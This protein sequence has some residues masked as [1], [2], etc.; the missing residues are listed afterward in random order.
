MIN[1]IIEIWYW[2]ILLI[3]LIGVVFYFSVQFVRDLWASV[4]RQLNEEETL[5]SRE[6]LMAPYSRRMVIIHWLTLALLLLAW[7]LGDMLVAARIEKAAPLLGYFAHALLGMSILMLTALR[8]IY[9]GEDGTPP[10]PGNSLLEMVG[11]GVHFGLY[12]LLI[13]LSISGFM[14]LLTSAVGLALVTGDTI[15]LPSEYTGPSLIPHLVHEVLVYVLI[16][17]VA[18]HM[19]GAARHQFIIRDGLMRRMWFGG[20][21]KFDRNR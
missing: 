9:R 8:L 11:R 20:R 15:V 6:K 21:K 7:Y 19:L 3:L 13:L 14:V 17:V 12:T 16:A 4:K 5:P 18:V 1:N 2:T 10:L